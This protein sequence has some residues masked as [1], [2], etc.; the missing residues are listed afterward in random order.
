MVFRLQLAL[1][2]V[3]AS[4]CARTILGSTPGP[5]LPGDS[6]A[7]AGGS[8]SAKQTGAE[9]APIQNPALVDD[10][11][12]SLTSAYQ[13]LLLSPK[14]ALGTVCGPTGG[15]TKA[16]SALSE[17]VNANRTDM[18]SDLSIRATTTEARAAAIVGLAKLRSISYANAEYM[19]R[20]LPG[21]LTTCKGRD[22]RTASTEAA[23][24]LLYVPVVG[25]AN[26]L[27]I[28]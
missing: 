20:R 25:Q 18:L 6:T 24:E 19:L 12:P 11:P 16:W 17:L 28:P 9:P 10:A 2:A 5:P 22:E 1:F 8:A 7:T 15:P 26:E 21:T 3:L 27:A 13:E 14:Q 23:A 4:G